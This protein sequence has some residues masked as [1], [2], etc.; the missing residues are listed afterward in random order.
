MNEA[1]KVVALLELADAAELEVRSVAVGAQPAG[2]PVPSS[3]VCR[4]RDQVWVVLSGGD[5]VEVH[6]RVLS[7]ALS[8]HRASWLEERWI[9][10]ALREIL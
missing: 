1:E 8:R 4:V 10:P 7:E 9:P 5:P 2:E 3:G 6:V